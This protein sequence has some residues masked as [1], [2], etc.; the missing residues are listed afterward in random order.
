MDG[1]KVSNKKKCIGVYFTI[2]N[3]DKTVNWQ[4]RHKFPLCLIPQEVNVQKVL[5]LILAP[6][7]YNLPSRP[8]VFCKYGGQTK[9]AKIAIARVICDTPG[10]A[11]FCG[12]K[13]H[14]AGIF[15]KLF[16]NIYI[17]FFYLVSPC[18]KCKITLHELFSM[19]IF[20]PKSQ[21]ELNSIWHNNKDDLS[22]LKK[23]L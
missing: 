11:E 15:F 10:V 12:T 21:Q 4:V 2:A 16:P 9:P 19:D 23:I 22:M 14:R 13:N 5:P 7:K 20:L 18:R 17:K 1:W 3:L 6:V 8:F